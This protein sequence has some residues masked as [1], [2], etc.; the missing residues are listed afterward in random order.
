[1][2][3]SLQFQ[4]ETYQTIWGQD[5]NLIFSWDYS[6]FPFATTSFSCEMQCWCFKRHQLWVCSDPNWKC[7]CNIRYRCISQGKCSCSNYLSWL[8]Q[9][10]LSG[11]FFRWIMT[12]LNFKKWYFERE[13]ARAT[14]NFTKE[15][16]TTPNTC[17]SYLFTIFFL[18][19]TILCCQHKI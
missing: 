6:N 1:M 8:E 2:P 11:R 15:D 16:Y 4:N 9:E 18:G 3:R 14:L 7:I 17:D 19:I 12:C 10:G 5:S 13:P